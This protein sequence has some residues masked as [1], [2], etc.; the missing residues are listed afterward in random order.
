M[1]IRRKETMMSL[2]EKF[3]V[4]D[5]DII[6]ERYSSY[7][8]TF[9]KFHNIHYVVDHSTGFMTEGNVRTKRIEILYSCL[10]QDYRARGS[11]I[12]N[13]IA[14]FPSDF[15]FR[16]KNISETLNNARNDALVH[17]YGLL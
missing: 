4:H 9:E 11:V 14:R 6:T 13:R 5:T 17:R 10:K 7:P 3:V 15:T 2:L 12:K 1:V 8:W 16:K